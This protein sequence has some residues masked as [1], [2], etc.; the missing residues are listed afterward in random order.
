M[1][2]R[3]IIR[4]D[5]AAMRQIDGFVASFVRQQGIA[6]DEAA[7]ILI[8]LEELLTN[9]VKYGY[10]DRAEPGQAEIVLALDGSRLQIE[11]ID[12]GCAFESLRSAAAQSRR[13]GRRPSGGRPRSPHPAFA[14]R[15]GVLRT[16]Q[17]KKC[18]STV[19]SGR[20]GQASLTDGSLGRSLYYLTV[21]FTA[22]ANR[23]CRSSKV[24]KLA[25]P[26]A[27]ADATWMM[28]RVRV[29]NVL[30]HFCASPRASA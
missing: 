5:S 28:S 22:L 26:S 30:V 27:N 11:F 15:R 29:P 20:I 6:A 23:R 9:L 8:L 25:A 19:S 21:S 16:P 13:A 2:S 7:R 14:D 17:R 10:P 24:W 12:D 3:L 18:D 1:Q 4:A